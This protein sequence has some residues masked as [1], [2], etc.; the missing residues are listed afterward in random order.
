MVWI[1]GGGFYSAWNVFLHSVN[2]TSTGGASLV[3][4]G[5]LFVEHSVARVCTSFDPDQLSL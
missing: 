4:D 3:Y 1:Y 5:A 2:S